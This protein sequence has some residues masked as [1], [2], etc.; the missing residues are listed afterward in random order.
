MKTE[1]I[2]AATKKRGDTIF[3][4]VGR[5]AKKARHC[6]AANGFGRP[7]PVVQHGHCSIRS[8]AEV[9]FYQDMARD[10]EIRMAGQHFRAAILNR[11]SALWTPQ[12]RRVGC[13]CPWDRKT[14]PE[15][16]LCKETAADATTTAQ[17]AHEG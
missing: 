12:T 13:L 15:A 5:L 2:T 16:V 3:P 1:G 14:L 7:G 10:L 11:S 9:R 6:G 8:K 17:H 4:G